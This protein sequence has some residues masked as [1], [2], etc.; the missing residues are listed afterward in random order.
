M[1]CRICRGQLRH[2]WTLKV[3]RDRHQADYYE[4]TACQ[5]LQVPDPYWL[6][7]AYRDESLPSGAV[8]DIGRFA[9]NFSAV[10]YLT[11]LHRAKVLAEFPAILDFGGGYGLLAQML[12]DSG[13]D[14][15]T[16]DPYVPEPFFAVNRCVKELAAIP[17][18]SY[19]AV[20]ALEVFEHLA[21]PLVTGDRLLRLLKPDGALVI[22]T[23]IYQ[24]EI[25][26]ENWG[27]LA[28]AGGQH[29]TFWTKTALRHFVTNLGLTSVGYFPGD[30]GFLII[31]S[32]LPGQVLRGRLA[33]AWRLLE[34]H[35]HY[36]SLSSPWDIRGPHWGVMGASSRPS[37]EVLGTGAADQV[38]SLEVRRHLG[39]W[40]VLRGLSRMWRI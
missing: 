13:Y 29:I 24:P 17:P 30:T 25:H 40:R 3:L 36:A 14:A 7:E 11:A 38:H 1:H 4:C 35:R 15:W 12:L 9:R 2:K 32:R 23:G 34:D 6:E 19:D 31:L 37:V 16:F 39:I 20:V 8:L 28:C 26:D 21:D 18:A 10:S 5:A 27:Y 33:R 22:S